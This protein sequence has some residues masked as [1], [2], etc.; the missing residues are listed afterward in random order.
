M[1]MFGAHTLADA[2]VCFSKAGQN[3]S[4]KVLPVASAVQAKN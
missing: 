3:L 1:G 4:I 2:L